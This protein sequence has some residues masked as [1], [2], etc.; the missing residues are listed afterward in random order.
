[1][2]RVTLAGSSAAGSD[3]ADGPVIRM[4][5][6]RIALLPALFFVI[7]VLPLASVRPWWLFILILPAGWISFV[8]RSSVDIGP[9]GVAVRGL[10]GE[11]RTPWERISGLMI[12][13]RRQLSLVTVD[14]ATIALPSLRVRDLSRLHTASKGRLGLS[15][16]QLSASTG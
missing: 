1:M 8:L 7:C 6:N 13:R 4:R 10:F 3:G 16:D 14:G 12:V 5:K 2:E 9:G 11:L 15:D